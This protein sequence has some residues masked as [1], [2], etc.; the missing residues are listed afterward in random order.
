MR[1]AASKSSLGLHLLFVAILLVN[2]SFWMQ[3]RTVLSQWDNVPPAPG[4]V[5]TAFSG[6]GDPEIAY[7]MFGY[8]LQNVG[9]TGGHYES[10]KKYDYDILGQWFFA[11]QS[12]DD[13][14]NYVPFLAAY[15]FGALDEPAD[16]LD[17][18]IDYLAAEG[19]KPYAQKWR[20][21][22][23]AVYLARYKQN[24]LDKALRLANILASLK[25]DMAPWARQMPAF[26]QIKM[27]NKQAAYEIMV[28]MLA[29]EGGK[30]QTIEVN[31]MKRYI[32]TRTLEPAEAAK[33]PLCQDVK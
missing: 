21:L 31:E 32:C 30:L 19:Q 13:R 25:T 20:W 7:R 8:F 10:L 29:S 16:K 15:Y 26:I 18:V 9:N 23:Q 12:L 1:I 3:S 27:G 11:A 4:K 22:A 28:R 24:D 33:N 14:A 5:A 2:F 6:L 17:P